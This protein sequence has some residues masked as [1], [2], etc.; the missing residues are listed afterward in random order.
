MEYLLFGDYQF[1]KNVKIEP[2]MSGQVVRYFEDNG[3]DSPIEGFINSEY[4]HESAFSQWILK[5]GL[6]SCI[7]RVSGEPN[8]GGG[9]F[10]LPG[11][12][13]ATANGV[14]TSPV[15]RGAWVLKYFGRHLLST[16]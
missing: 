9:I 10:T 12:M 11:L 4:L 1:Y 13:T 3:V 14:D 7:K 8:R 6:W 2:M 5:E 15:V 16:S